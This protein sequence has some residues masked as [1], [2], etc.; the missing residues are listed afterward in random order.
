MENLDWW[1][2]SPGISEEWGPDLAFVRLPQ[3]GGFIE[4]LKSKKSFWNLSNDSVGRIQLANSG[5]VFAAVCGFVDEQ[6]RDGEPESGFNQ[7]KRLQGYAFIGG[8]TGPRTVNGYDFIDVAG[9][10]TTCPYIPSDFGGVS[11]GGLWTFSVNRQE[12]DPAGAEKLADL[13]LAGVA[14]YQLERSSDKPVVRSHGPHSV[15]QTALAQILNWFQ[16]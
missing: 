9:D 10:R 6:T 3:S 4:E 16:G 13:T 2:T 14:F 11:G 8:P 7:V 12:G 15:Y 1:L 5:E